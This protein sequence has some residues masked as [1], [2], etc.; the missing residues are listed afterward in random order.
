[1]REHL[2]CCEGNTD[3]WLRKTYDSLG[4]FDDFLILATSQIII[5]YTLEIAIGAPRPNLPLYLFSPRR[6]VS[7]TN[8]HKSCE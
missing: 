4:V 6:M 8:L 5:I 3:I 1:M 7:A 2:L